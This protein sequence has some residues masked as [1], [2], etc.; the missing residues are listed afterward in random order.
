MNGKRPIAHPRQ[1]PAAIS[2]VLACTMATGNAWASDLPVTSCLDD[3]SAGTLRVVVAN[4]TS[5]DTIDLASQLSCST[6]TL[7]SNRGEIGSA[8]NLTLIG[9]ADRTVTI[10]GG[11]SSRVFYAY[12]AGGTINLTNLTV[13]GGY[14]RGAGGCIKATKAAVLDHS[15]VTNCEIVL[16]PT[17]AQGGGIYAPSV[18]LRNGS[19]VTGNSSITPPHYS[20]YFDFGGGVFAKDS[21]SCSDSTIS[22]NYA[23]LAGGGIAGTG[24]MSISR[25]TIDSNMAATGGGIATITSAAGPVTIAQSTIS[26]N[27]AVEGGGIY[28]F[29]MTP[30]DMY[31]STVAFNASVGSYAGGIYSRGGISAQSSIIADN[32]QGDGTPY[33]VEIPYTSTLSGADNAVVATNTAPA[34]GVITVTADP[35]LAPLANHGGLTR[36]HALLAGSAVIDQG[37]NSQSFGNDQRGPGFNRVV[38]ADADIGAYERQLVDDEIFANG[39]D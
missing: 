26:G 11:G 32:V 39:F 29:S 34:P 20:K 13:A 21:F 7:D 12:D 33:D 28:L 9:P 3:L 10:Q 38:G 6:I 35:R 36:T 4:A 31:N 17:F 1:L 22:G 2:L 25:C 23:R 18:T 16:Y 27:T 30:L 37:N 14:D 5:S 24:S 19:V 15:T 8:H